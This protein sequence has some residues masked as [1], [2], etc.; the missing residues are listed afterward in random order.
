[1]NKPDAINRLSKLISQL[2]Q[3]AYEYYVL[4]KT[5]VSDAVYDGLIQEVK[6]IEEEYPDLISPESPT[7]RVGAGPADDFQKVPHST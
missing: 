2:S 3:Y 4:D 5:T 1:M 7:Q 6:K